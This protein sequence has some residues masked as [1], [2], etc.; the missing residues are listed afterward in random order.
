MLCYCMIQAVPF[1]PHTLSGPVCF[2]HPLHLANGSFFLFLEVAWVCFYFHGLAVPPGSR[3]TLLPGK[4]APNFESDG[5]CSPRIPEPSRYNAAFPPAWFPQPAFLN[6][7]VFLLFGFPFGII[8]PPLVRQH[9]IL[10]NKWG[11]F[12]S[13]GLWSINHLARVPAPRHWIS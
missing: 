3:P 6:P 13:A 9:T 4:S 1:A 12:N 8:K 5:D 2:Q 7:D 11:H 10:S